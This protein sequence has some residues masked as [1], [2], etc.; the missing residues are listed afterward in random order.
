VLYFVGAGVVSE[1]LVTSTTG[2]RTEY[3]HVG[4]GG[5]ERLGS[6]AWSLA[7]SSIDDTLPRILVDRELAYRARRWLRGIDWSLPTAVSQLSDPKL[8]AELAAA[9]TIVK[10]DR[11][12]IAAVKAGL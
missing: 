10:A 6:M 9:L 8:R 3:W 12:L 5:F 2:D 7:E 4:R 11:A 1:V